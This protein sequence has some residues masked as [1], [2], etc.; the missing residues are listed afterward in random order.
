MQKSFLP[1][2]A[3]ELFACLEDKAQAAPQYFQT[4]LTLSS[5]E[6]LDEVI[7]DLVRPSVRGLGLA[8]TAEDGIVVQGLSRHIITSEVQLRTLFR[9]A[10]DNRAS[11]TLPVGGSIDTSSAIWELGLHQVQ[12]AD[13]RGI[14]QS[15]SRLIVV[16]VPAVDPLMLGAR[17]S[18]IGCVLSIINALECY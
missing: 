10:C 17:C 15:F 14:S 7:T 12:G 16:D 9:D 13:G 2:L 3:N 5:F 8:M 11:H 4:Q 1:F 6:V 18:H